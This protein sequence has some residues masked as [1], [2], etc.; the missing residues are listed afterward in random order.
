MNYI[1]FILLA[2]AALL[3]ITSNVAKFVQLETIPYGMHVDELSGA[4]TLHCLAKTN[5]TLH[6]VHL[7]LFADMCYGTPKPPTFLYPG[8]LWVKAFGYSAA[9]I[10]SLSVA[11]FI[12]ALI[13]LFL[14]ARTLGGNRLALFTL[15]AASISPWTW[16]SSRIGIE[17][18]HHATFL[19]WGL[20]FLL[21]PSRWHNL[22]CAGLLLAATMYAYPPVR[23]FIP[24]ML[25]PVLILKHS[26]EKLSRKNLVI[27]GAAF[28][29][30]LLP[31]IHMYLTSTMMTVRFNQISIFSETY[32]H[33]IGKT[34]SLFDIAGVFINNFLLHLSPDFLFFRGNPSLIHSTGHFGILSWLDIAA[35]FILLPLMIKKIDRKLALIL[36]LVTL[37][38]IVP[39]ALTN[40]E[41][42]H[43]VRISGSWPFFM[44]LVGHILACASRNWKWVLPASLL[45]SWAFA[46]IFCCTYFRQYPQESKWMFRFQVMEEAKAAKT[47]R[48]WMDFL[49]KNKEDIWN[50]W[51]YLMRYKNMSCA[52]AT[53][54]WRALYHMFKRMDA[55]NQPGRQP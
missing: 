41:L 6:D 19:V 28:F 31:L 30:A 9:G 23:A 38:G 21:R 2:L 16:T 33:S 5:K 10:R 14:L 7:P 22:L 27:L 15:I 55:K 25:I 40:S 42:P 12:L 52:E 34:K 17:S 4:A 39:S 35:I 26:R 45:I 36:G 3:I 13:G 48:Q 1:K 20:W 37:A 51:Y 29:L 53:K 18:L 49:Y 46:I 44:L 24:L 47:D 50:C 32:L 11:F 43:N 8:I 54:T